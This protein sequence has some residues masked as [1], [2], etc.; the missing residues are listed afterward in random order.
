[1]EGTTRECTGLGRRAV[2]EVGGAFVIV[3][4][5]GLSGSFIRTKCK[6]ARDVNDKTVILVGG[7]FWADTLD[8]RGPACGMCNRCLGV[9]WGLG[10][11]GV[12]RGRAS[13][14]CGETERPE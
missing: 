1:M 7:Y 5:K 3:I 12:G 2:S 10:I 4:A 9:V 8:K 13:R 6:P 11:R 14:C